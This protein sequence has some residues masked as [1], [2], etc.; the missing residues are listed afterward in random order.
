[1]LEDIIKESYIQFDVEAKDFEEAIRISMT[2]LLEDEAVDETYVE[3][4]IRIYK[5]T[6]PYIVLTKHIALPHAPSSSG[7]KKVAL[8]FTRLKHSV[9]SGNESNDPVCLLFG[10]SAPD[11]DSHL[12]I[13]AQLVQVLSDEEA[14]KELYLAKTPKQVI[15]IL[16]K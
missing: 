1:M 10:L 15:N 14:I 12:E 7:A 6:G 11:S 8:G 16:K 5:T 9:I 13:L 4:I 2:P 3:E